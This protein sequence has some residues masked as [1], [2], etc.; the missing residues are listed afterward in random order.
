MA[1]V[2][3]RT[4][5]A[6]CVSGGRS[7]SV[8]AHSG[9]GTDRSCA[10]PPLWGQ[11]LGWSSP[12][13]RF[14]FRYLALS[15]LWHIRTSRQR[16]YAM[17]HLGRRRYHEA[18]GVLLGDTAL[19]VSFPCVTVQSQANVILCCSWVVECCLVSPCATLVC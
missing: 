7:V 6:I 17:V 4:T 10:A 16:L 3:N 9:R 19:V 13:C 14:Q 5:C 12:C 11:G 18:S 2:E 1:K 15:R 8:A